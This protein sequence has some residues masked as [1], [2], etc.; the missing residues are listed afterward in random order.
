[1]QLVSNDTG[2][3]C[4]NKSEPIAVLGDAPLEI[5]RCYSLTFLAEGIKPNLCWGV[6][7]VLS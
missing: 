7:L 5:D 3:M 2:V 4:S 1:V 6:F